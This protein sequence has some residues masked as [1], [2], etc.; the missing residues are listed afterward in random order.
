MSLSITVVLKVTNA[1]E[2]IHRLY[3]VYDILIRMF[4]NLL[5]FGSFC[6]T[7]KSFLKKRQTNKTLDLAKFQHSRTTVPVPKTSSA[8]A[9]K[10]QNKVCTCQTVA[11]SQRHTNNGI[12]MPWIIKYNDCFTNIIDLYFLHNRSYF[13]IFQFNFLNLLFTSTV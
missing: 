6:N 13:S 10:K 7:F 8:T 2:M 1:L 5:M 4:K 9:K 3:L 12:L 11:K